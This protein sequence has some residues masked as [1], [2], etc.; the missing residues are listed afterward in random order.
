MHLFLYKID[1]D[2]NGIRIRTVH[3]REE[4][5]RMKFTSSELN[6]FRYDLPLLT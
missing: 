4:L 2:G 5:N 3:G 1:L 6:T